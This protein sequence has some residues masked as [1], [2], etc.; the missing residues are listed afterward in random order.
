M[1][2][3][4]VHVHVK[5][6]RVEE[7]VA[8]TRANHDASVREPGNRRFDVLQST[9]DPS[10]FVLYEA[11]ASAEDAAAHKGTAHYA[12]WRD[13]VADMMAEPRKGVPYAGLLP[14]DR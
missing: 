1:H 10:R 4:L 3:T 9:E 6:E 7:F 8:A 13:R 5:P 12:A 14:V 2:V 11:Y